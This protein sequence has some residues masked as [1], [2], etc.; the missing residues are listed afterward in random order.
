MQ[1]Y[2]CIFFPFPVRE[3]PF[4]LHKHK[5]TCAKRLYGSTLNFER[6][7]T[8]ILIVYGRCVPMYSSQGHS[9]NLRGPEQTIIARH[10]YTVFTLCLYKYLNTTKRSIAV[11]TS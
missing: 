11:I 1:Q 2:T 6:N 5:R 8:N 4:F 10:F 3:Y 7:K 9:W